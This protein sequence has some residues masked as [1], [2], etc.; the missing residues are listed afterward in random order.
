[1]VRPSRQPGGAPLRA[2]P[3]GGVVMIIGVV[4]ANRK[5]FDL[6]VLTN[7]AYQNKKAVSP[8]KNGFF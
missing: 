6:L 1:M 8:K 4:N 7:T 3:P 2:A 5:L